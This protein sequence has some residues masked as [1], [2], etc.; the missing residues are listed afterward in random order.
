M[1]SIT[2]SL[3]VN[4]VVFWLLS[5]FTP[6]IVIEDTK[7]LI[8]TAL[9]LT[10]V[11]LTI[12]PVLKLVTLPLNILTLGLFSWAYT[13]V[14]LYLAISAIPGV[15]ITG[16]VFP[17]FS[18]MGFTIPAVGFSRLATLAALSIVLSL[19]ERIVKHIL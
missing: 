1:K 19:V 4:G 11:N 5:K 7:S 6:A 16:F 15:C 3:L 14:A 2:R 10:L 13:L 18:G 12:K 9:A 17:G 8:L